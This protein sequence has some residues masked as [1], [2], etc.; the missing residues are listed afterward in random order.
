MR[1]NQFAHSPA[2]HPA[3]REA[4]VP[5][6]EPQCPRSLRNPQTVAFSTGPI[7]CHPNPQVPFVVEADA[8]TTGV[9]AVLSQQFGEPPSL[10]ACAFFSRKL[11]PA[12]QNYDIRNMELLAIKLALEEW[13]DW[14]EGANHPFTVITDNKNLQYLREAK[15]LNP[16]QAR[17]A[18]LFTRFE[19]TITY[20]PCSRNCKADALSRLYTPDSPV[21]TELILPPDLVVNPIL[22]N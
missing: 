6:L 8:S 14:L 16:R 4:Q 13:R 10:Q 7:L 19:F 20:R 22:W 18:L 2:H 11:T 3:S 17:W 12:E 21:D 9:G 15:R 1:Y 5:V